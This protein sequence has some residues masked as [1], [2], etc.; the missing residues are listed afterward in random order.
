MKRFAQMR[1]EEY[2]KLMEDIERFKMVEAEQLPKLLADLER[3]FENYEREV[4]PLSDSVKRFW[5]SNVALGD[6]LVEDV[7]RFLES[8]G[9]QMAELEAGMSRFVKFGS[10]EWKRFVKAVK[11]QTFSGYDAAFGDRSV[12]S[13][14]ERSTRYSKMPI[15]RHR[16][17][18]SVIT[19]FKFL[20]T[21]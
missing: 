13:V 4:A 12:P 3:F 17:L 15:W 9:P 19:G 21:V 1:G 6:L 20:F 18:P 5:R 14:Q 10:V 11:G 8:S 2:I 16:K 7:K